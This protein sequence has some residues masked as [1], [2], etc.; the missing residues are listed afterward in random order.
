MIKVDIIN[1][2]GGSYGGVEN[3]IRE[4][5]KNLD[6]E[7]FF[8]RVFHCYKGMDYL[9]GFDNVY[10]IS[11]PFE[12]A[13]INHLIEA[14][15]LFIENYGPSDICIANNWP[16]MTLAC[17]FVRQ[18]RNLNDMKIVSWI[19]GAMAEYERE[20]VGGVTELTNADFHL[21]LS[22]GYEKMI[23]D[24]DPNARI[25]NIGNPIDIPEY[26]ECETDPY[27]LCYVGR[28]SEVKRIDIIL[29]AIY[30]AKGPWKLKLVGNGDIKEEVDGWID[31]LKLNDRVIRVDWSSDPWNDCR[32]SSIMVSASEYEG[33]SLSAHE[34]SA[35]GKTV[36]TTPVDGITDYIA[37]GING[38]YFPQEDAIALADILNR[39]EEGTIKVCNPKDC[40]DSVMRFR[41]DNYFKNVMAALEEMTK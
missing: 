40:I 18:Q 5:A 37:D 1:P 6:R 11:V 20:E 21:A 27:L 3:V 4:W 19:H 36:I 15:S 10:N 26:T 8:L 32:D 38:Y 12:R 25:F 33:F 17:A 2:T 31:L 30:R 7:K 41:T 13:D 34:A 24:A 35:R 9:K 14:Y 29:E 39:I 28:L 16:M 23:L 22:H